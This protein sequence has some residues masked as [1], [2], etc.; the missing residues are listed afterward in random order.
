[1]S[2]ETLEISVSVQENFDMNFRHMEDGLD[3]LLSLL[4]VA[5]IKVENS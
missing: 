5:F 3:F 4:V 1:M 2:N